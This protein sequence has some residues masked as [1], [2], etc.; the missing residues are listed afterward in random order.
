MCALHFLAQRCKRFSPLLAVPA[1]LLLSQG[2]A[3]ALLTYYIFENAGNVVVQTR[4]SLN[5]TGA[6]QTGT[7]YCG[8][9]GAIISSAAAICT[10]ADPRM[11]FP[12]FAISGP[13]NFNGTASIYPASSVSGIFI[14]LDGNN[15][16]FVIDPTYTTNTPIVSSATFNG[17]T[18]A[19]LNFTTT[20]LIGT[21]SLT[22]TSETIQVILGAPP[23]A[24]VPG[25]LPLL[26]AGAAFGW[27]RRLRKRTQLP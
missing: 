16:R 3:K 10:G 9:D 19:G 21:W 24:S 23:S 2:D 5:L 26:G 7:L 15:Q 12:S 8:A 6:T 13:K 1:A 14:D 25:P 17:K 22:G 18:L 4:G 27:A 20:G 11:E